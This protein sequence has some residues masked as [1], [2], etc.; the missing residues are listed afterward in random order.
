MNSSMQTWASCCA[1]SLASSCPRPTRC[2]PDVHLRALYVRFWRPLRW[3][4]WAT[5]PPTAPSGAG[6]IPRF[7]KDAQVHRT[8]WGSDPLARGSYSFP[9]AGASDAS[10]WQ[11]LAQPLAAK[12]DGESRPTGDLLGL[13]AS[14]WCHQTV[15]LRHQG[16]LTSRTP[17]VLF[18][19][20]ATEQG[21]Y[22][23]AHGAMMSGRREARRLL[24]AWGS[25]QHDAAVAA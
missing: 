2:A 7:K 3:T 16:R 5:A 12:Q 15:G 22:G 23:T 20:E 13:A 9:V 4:C 17:A 25:M 14:A 24:Q 11:T 10:A 21:H 8:R 6:C 18:A 1:A 19:G